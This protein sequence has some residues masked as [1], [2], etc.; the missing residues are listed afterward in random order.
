VSGRKVRLRCLA[1][2]RANRTAPRQVLVPLPP[3]RAPRGEGGRSPDG[4]FR[5]AARKT[6]AKV[7]QGMKDSGYP[8]K[9]GGLLGVEH[10]NVLDLIKATVVCGGIAFLVYSFPVL[11][12]AAIIGLLGALWLS[13]AGKTLKTVRRK[14]SL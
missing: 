4:R 2:S 1:A 5:L 11:S 7:L 3:I 6:S 13:Y 8:S 14:C 9:S 10:M 12:Q